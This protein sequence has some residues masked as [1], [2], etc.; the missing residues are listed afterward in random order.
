MNN[1]GYLLAANVIVWVVLFFYIYS[2][3]RKNS[4]LGKEIETLFTKLKE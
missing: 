3:V 4:K 2:L 1:L